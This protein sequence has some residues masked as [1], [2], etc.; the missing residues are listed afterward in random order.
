VNLT[1]KQLVMSDFRGT[2]STVINFELFRA[3]GLLN[4]D[5]AKI[6]ETLIARKIDVKNDAFEIFKVAEIET[7]LN[8]KFEYTY[9][10]LLRDLRAVH[11]ESG[12]FNKFLKFPKEHRTILLSYVREM[13]ECKGLLT[14]HLDSLKILGYPKP[15]VLQS[16]GVNFRNQINE[17]LI[18]SL[19]VNFSEIS[20]E[21]MR[22]S[23]SVSRRDYT[24]YMDVLDTTFY[25]FRFIYGE[26]KIIEI[27]RRVKSEHFRGDID[28]LMKIAEIY[29]NEDIKNYPL[30]WI[31]QLI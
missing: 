3:A 13:S 23:Y 28:S 26:K 15:I 2:D 5:A 16:I 24:S 12:S 9:E 7:D 19:H 30:V 31:E 29:E 21:F 6:E 22:I 1:D 8:S 25:W 17:I 10:E 11:S 18:N 4:P 14:A 27:L 20:D